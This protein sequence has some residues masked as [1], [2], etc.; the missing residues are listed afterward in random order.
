MISFFPSR[1]VAIELFGLSIHWYGLMYLLAF[2]LAFVLLPRLQRFRGL[3][4]TKDDWASLLS[5]GIIGVIVGGRLGFVIFYEPTHFAEYPLEIFQIWHGGMSSHGGFLGVA[6]AFAYA[7]KKKGIDP[8]LLADLLVVPIAIGLALGRIG[9]FINEEL[10]GVVTTMSWAINVTGVEGLRHPTQ[11]YAVA[12]DLLI[13]GVCLWHLRMVK[14]VI[15]GRTFALFLILYSVLRYIVEY[16]RVQEY[17]LLH[18]GLIT[19]SRGQLLTVPLL[20]VGVI[21]WWQLGRNA[22]SQVPQEE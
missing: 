2:L 5:W 16:F 15:V 4:L 14:P 13:A 1:A 11:L 10:Y 9:N 8:L 19:M 18:F 20:I 7:C 3:S 21:L 17:G 12:K 22:S 6:I